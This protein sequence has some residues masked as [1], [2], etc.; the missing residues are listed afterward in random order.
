MC[1]SVSLSQLQPPT[2]NFLV[3]GFR[4][5]IGGK[6]ISIPTVHRITRLL[7]MTVG[8]V[9][10]TSLQQTAQLTA[11]GTCF[12]T[13]HLTRAITDG[14]CARHALFPLGISLFVAN[15]RCSQWW[16]STNGGFSVLLLR[17]LVT[18]R[19]CGLV[20]VG[21]SLLGDCGPL[22]SRSAGPPRRTARPGCPVEP[23]RKV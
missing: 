9:S 19:L 11:D 13:G 3:I 4:R 15:V 6:V 5:S 18:T 17:S 20:Y 10:A 23:T 8:S 22:R 2:Q 14:T 12:T 21:G 1:W 16:G 7:P